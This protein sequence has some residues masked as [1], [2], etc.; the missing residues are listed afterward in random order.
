MSTPENVGQEGG[1][2]ASLVRVLLLLFVVGS[3]GYMTVRGG[4]GAGTS[5]SL[6]PRASVVPA[7]VRPTV[8]VYFFDADI[9]C[10]SC[11]KIE[12]YT[13]RTLETTFSEGLGSGRI[14]WRVLNTDRAENEHYLTDYHLYS[15]SIVLVEMKDGAEVRWENLEKIWD[16][17]YDEEGFVAYIEERVGAF[18]GGVS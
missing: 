7:G 11:E 6:T 12:T 8:I 14:A 9:R 10:S 5:S 2:G 3:V 15:K 4:G 16:L 17:V 18:L 1:K 13:Y